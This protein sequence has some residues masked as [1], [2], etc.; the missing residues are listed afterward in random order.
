MNAGRL[1]LP[2]V[3]SPRATRSAAVVKNFSQISLS[4]WKRDKQ[5]IFSQ[6]WRFH[7]EIYHEIILSDFPV[8][9]FGFFFVL[10]V[11]NIYKCGK[12]VVV[13]VSCH[14]IESASVCIDSVMKIICAA[15][16]VTRKL[17]ALHIY[18]LDF[19]L[20]FKRRRDG[21]KKQNLDTVA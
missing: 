16:T 4:H 8:R 14:F 1:G 6:P 3:C 10:R 18:R 12:R 11:C 7:E 17:F 19:S 2:V 15:S 13:I 20:S 5:T 21:I 9:R